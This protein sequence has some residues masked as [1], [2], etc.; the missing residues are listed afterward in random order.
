MAERLHDVRDVFGAVVFRCAFPVSESV[1]VDLQQSWISE[2]LGDSSPL[3]EDVVSHVI[4]QRDGSL[5]LFGKV[6]QRLINLW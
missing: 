4:S 6:I 1:K 2:F 5:G 3:S